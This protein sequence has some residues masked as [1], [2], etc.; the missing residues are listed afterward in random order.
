MVPSVPERYPSHRRWASLSAYVVSAVG[1]LALVGWTFDIALLRSVHPGFV[2][3]NPTTALAFILSGAALRISVLQTTER[4]IR[5]L[6]RV[7]G[8][9]VGLLG[10]LRLCEYL[11]GWDLGVNVLL[12]KEQVLALS[13][14]NRMAATTALTFLLLGFAFIVQDAESGGGR[15]LAEPLILLSAFL[16]L[17]AV[18]GYIYQNKY[19]YDLTMALHTALT[20]LVLCS[21]LLCARPDYGFMKIVF[22]ERLGG[23]FARRLFPAAVA[24][25]LIL[26][27]MKLEGQRAGWYDVE[28]GSALLTALRIVILVGFIWWTS[29]SLDRIDAERRS[30]EE[31]LRE[32][33]E[34]I[35]LL[36]DSTAEAIYGIN[37][38][39]FCT[40]CNASSLRLLGYSTAA[41][42]IGKNMHNLVHH[43]KPDG[44]PY[45]LE[46]CKLYKAFRAGEESQHG[47]EV[48]W[49]AGGSS[50]PIEYWSYPVRQNGVT[51]GSVVAFIDITERKRTENEMRGTNSKLTALVD[52]L[53]ARKREMSLLNEMGNLLQTCR[54]LQ[55]AND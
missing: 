52:E 44:S 45:P 36:L 31:K 7:C 33:S 11:F 40:F 5:L 37:L 27:V 43:S 55:E 20:L 10:F 9:A 38:Q 8:L 25:P 14:P 16:S 3:M 48:L 22:S 18:I 13:P 53:E 17:I 50:F 21:G 47:D 24:L 51:I 23:V 6:G 15:R 26:D 49:H 4:R 41:E 39:G 19:F 12:L 42:L 2:A 54:S 34:R 32:S 35:Q 30:N 46:E 28:T 1:C 29:I